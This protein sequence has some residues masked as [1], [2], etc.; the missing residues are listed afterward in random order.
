MQTAAAIPPVISGWQRPALTPVAASERIET[1]DVLRGVALF[2][3]LTVNMVGFSWPPEMML[4][5]QLFWETRTDAIADGFIR[6]LAEGKFYPLFAFL[7]GLGAAIQLERAASCGANFTSRFCRRMLTL[8]GFGLAHGLLLWEGDIL[9][10]YAIGGFLLLPFRNRQPRTLLIWGVLCWLI[11]VLL[12]LL[13]WVG[14]VG[15]SFVP[16]LAEGIQKQLVTE[17]E[18]SAR[19]IE[20]IIR[21]FSQGSY[22]E[23]FS[24]RAGNVCYAWLMGIFYAPGILAMFLLGLYAGKRHIF[25]DLEAHVGC[26]RR[27]F[28]WGLIVGLPANLLFTIGMAASDLSDVHFGWLLCQALVGLGGP[29]QSLAYAAGITLL[30]RQDAWKRWLTLIA[31]PGRMALSNYIFQSL[32]CTTI[33]YSYGLGLFGSMGRAAGLGLT[34]AIYV[35]QVGLS[36]W[37]LNRFQFGPLEWLWRSITYGKL[38]P[39]QR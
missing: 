38:Q 28:I 19:Q 26:L 16:Q 22:A 21:V 39:M 7:F 8:L 30:L 10:W 20:E 29:A 6:F 4:M 18:A 2:G 37:W 14:L 35:S 3:I 25:R 9:V 31:A 13:I 36:R 27:V 1:L 5:R 11:P 32:I 33:F 15:L 17:S 23:V 24:A 34:V 12:I